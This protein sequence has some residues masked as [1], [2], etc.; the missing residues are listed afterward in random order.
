MLDKASDPNVQI[1]DTERTQLAEGGVTEPLFSTFLS[2]LAAW[3][4]NDLSQCQHGGSEMHSYSHVAG[5]R[6]SPSWIF[7]R[8]LNLPI[9]NQP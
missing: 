6:V 4:A 2:S 3:L 5:C 1:S 7:V 9:T 8:F